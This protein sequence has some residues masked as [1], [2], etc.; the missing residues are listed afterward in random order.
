MRVGLVSGRLFDRSDV[1]GPTA[2]VIIDERLAEKWWPGREAVGRRLYHPTDMKNITA[3][4]EDTV[5]FTLIGGVRV[6]R[7]GDPRADLSPVGAYY[8][9]SGAAAAGRPSSPTVTVRAR[10]NSDSVLA[11]VRQVI[12][13][14]DPD[15][16]VYRAGPM[17][18]RID[19]VFAARRVPMYIAVAFGLVGVLL[20]AVGIY[21]VLA[22]GVAQRRRELGVRMALGSA[23]AQVLMLVLGDGLKITGLGLTAGLAGALL[24]GRAMQSQLFGVSPTEPRVMAAVAVALGVIGLAASVIPSWRATRIDPVTALNK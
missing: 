6:V 18:E 8:F 23:P 3:V 4:T 19:D 16:P 20:A 2:S 5:F 12:A 15:L 10:T 22:C 9:P 7:L 21:G 11:Q 17:S 24:V 1:T 13:G 14:I